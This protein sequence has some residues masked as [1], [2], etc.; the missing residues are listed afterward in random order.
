MPF[1]ADRDLFTIEPKLF[2]SADVPYILNSNYSPRSIS[3][4]MFVALKNG[5][6]S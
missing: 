4:L 6:N 2:A 1:K 3:E 5:K